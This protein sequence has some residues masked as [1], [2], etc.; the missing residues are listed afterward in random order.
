MLY[1]HSERIT[2][3]LL[4]A[5]IKLF[6]LFANFVLASNQTIQMA[7]AYTWVAKK[8]QDVNHYG[9]RLPVSLWGKLTTRNQLRKWIRHANS[10]TTSIPLTCQWRQIKKSF[11]EG[12]IHFKDCSL[13]AEHLLKAWINTIKGKLWLRKKTLTDVYIYYYLP[14]YCQSGK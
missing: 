4:A 7:K 14:K 3:L 12:W 11:G 10:N 5:D 9:G 1:Y 6:F 13:K 2:V 8:K